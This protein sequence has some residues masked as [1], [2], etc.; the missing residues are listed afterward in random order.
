MDADLL[1]TDRQL[2]LVHLVAMGTLMV[3]NGTLL[4]EGNY[5]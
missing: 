1:I 4:R 2:E 5:E 3:E